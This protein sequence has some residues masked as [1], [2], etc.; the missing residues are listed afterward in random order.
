VSSKPGSAVELTISSKLADW[1]DDDPSAIKETAS[2]WDKVVV[3]KHM[4][5]LAELEVCSP[6]GP[7]LLIDPLHA[8]PHNRKSQLSSLSSRKTSAKKP[9]H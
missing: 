2:K 4:F 8:N 7:L 6:S 1:D 9:K 5:T 3:L